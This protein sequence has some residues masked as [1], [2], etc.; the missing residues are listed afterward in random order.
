MPAVSTIHITDLKLVRGLLLFLG[1]IE[2]LP[3]IGASLMTYS[4]CRVLQP[5]LQPLTTTAQS[6]ECLQN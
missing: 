2:D 6:Q 5:V 1:V 4:V 3:M